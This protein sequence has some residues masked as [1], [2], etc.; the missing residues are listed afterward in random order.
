VLVAKKQI[1]EARTLLDD[2]VAVAERTKS[3]Y[4]GGVLADRAKLARAENQWAK[5]AEFDTRAI[6]AFEA[7]AG[8]ESVDLWKPLTGLGLAMI[9]D[10]KRTEARPHLER[11]LAI[12]T[13]AKIPESTLRELRKALAKL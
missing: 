12:A 9:N 7:S 3:A 10:N 5:S 11:A 8:K 1:A 4:L 2:A 13:K 6:A